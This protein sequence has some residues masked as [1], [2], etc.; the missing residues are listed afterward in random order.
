MTPVDVILALIIV[1]CAV[2]L[3]WPFLIYPLILRL[4]PT[5]PVQHAGGAVPPTVS[6]LFCAYN[7]AAS[8]PT[9]IEN[10]RALKARHPALQILAFDDGSGDGTGDLLGQA[11]DVLTLL[12][13]PGRSGKAHGMKQLAAMAT[14]DILVFTDANVLLDANA[15]DALLPYY[16]DPQVGGVLGSLRYDGADRSASASV[17]AFYW[18]LEEHLKDLESRTGNVMGADGSIFSIGRALYPDFPDS[19]LDDLT[20]SMAVVFA[21]RRLIKAKDV[22]AREA[23]VAQRAD[24]YRRKVRIAARSWHTHRHLRPGLRR[25]SRLDRFKYGSRKIVRWF[26]GLWIGLA[27][28]AALAL[29]WRITPVAA[30]ALVAAGLVLAMLGAM[31]RRGPLAAIFD[32]LLAY[33]A[34]LKGVMLAMRGQTFTLWTPAKSR[35]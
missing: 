26:G 16:A 15:I 22:I 5:K 33:M 14:G 18:R 24:E 32:L 23:M 1:L 28:L 12:R 9:K 19:V 21:G 20:V 7:E 3:V 31:A 2:L 10:L 13:G 6:L 34:T 8:L 25:M 27:V 30:V 29:A 35:D 17:G 11:Q 4:L